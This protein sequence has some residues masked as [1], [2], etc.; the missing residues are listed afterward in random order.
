MLATNSRPHGCLASCLTFYLNQGLDQQPGCLYKKMFDHLFH[1]LFFFQYDL[2]LFGENKR[3][4]KQKCSAVDIAQLRRLLSKHF[5]FQ[6]F[7]V[8]DSVSYCL[9]DSVVP[10]GWS[11]WQ[12]T[13]GKFFEIQEDFIKMT[14]LI[15]PY[16]LF[17]NMENWNLWNHWNFAPKL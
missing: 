3:D 7:F 4:N 8:K 13:K 16:S 15:F 14:I 12:T 6:L 11:P 1:Y 2:F 5:C 10:W 9:L 17:Q